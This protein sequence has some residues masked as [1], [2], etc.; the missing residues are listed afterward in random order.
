MDHLS[1]GRM[2]EQIDTTEAPDP[3]LAALKNAEQF[4]HF[5]FAQWLEDQP[6][7]LR[8]TALARPPSR[9]Y[10]LGGSYVYVH[11]YGK[12]GRVVVSILGDKECGRIHAHPNE[13]HD[14]TRELREKYQLSWMPPVG[15]EPTNSGF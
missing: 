2:T 15:V 11:G 7:K 5:S 10:D 14:V 6:A 13:L 1:E 12:D 3:V 8:R 4:D 9:V